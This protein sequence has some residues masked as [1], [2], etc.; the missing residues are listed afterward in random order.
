MDDGWGIPWMLASDLGWDSI[1]A[2]LIG[3]KLVINTI[4][5]RQYNEWLYRENL[6]YSRIEVVVD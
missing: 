3:S 1:R 4:S 2:C 6:L 5:V